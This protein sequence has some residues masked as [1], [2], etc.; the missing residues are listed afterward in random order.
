MKAIT[1]R[2][3]FTLVFVAAQNPALAQIDEDQLGIWTAYSWSTRSTESNWGL[4][5]DFQL[6]NWDIYNDLEQRLVRAGVTYSP[7]SN[8][9]IYRF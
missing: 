8:N 4:Q 3:L 1:F 9:N 5:G 6:R 7:D 2:A